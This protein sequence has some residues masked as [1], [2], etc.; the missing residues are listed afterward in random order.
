MLEGENCSFECVLSH[1]IIDEALWIL[2]GQLIVSN[3]RI[4]VANKGR[5]YTMSIQEVIISD[6]GEVVFTIKDLSCRTM[7]FVKGD[8]LNITNNLSFQVQHCLLSVSSVFSEKPVRVFRDMLNVKATPGEDPELSCEIT[9]PDATVKWLK[10]GRLI[11]VS[12]KY[13]IIQKDYLVKLIIHN[14]AIRDS[15]EYCCEA[16]GIA[17]RARLD[18]RGKY[19][20]I[21]YYKVT[22][23]TLLY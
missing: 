5:K 20:L 9:K 21:P 7:L 11:R 19:F 13:E 10:N 16:D 22:F 8:I 23:Y 4:I 2:N 15:G 12:P 1:D 17:T 6:A 18:V 14:A 3:G